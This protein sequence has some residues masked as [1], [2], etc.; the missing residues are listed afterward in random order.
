MPES[1]VSDT[2]T[3]VLRD[4]HQLILG[5]VD[6]LDRTLSDTHSAS[7]LDLDVID[8]C[9]SFFRLFA[10]A[11]HHGKEEDLLFPELVEHGMPGDAGPIAVM[12]SEH[13]QGRLFVRGMA[14]AMAGAGSGNE[15]SISA[16]RSHAEDYI[17]LIRAH[18]GKEDHILFVMADD[19]VVGD[20]CRVLCD[21]YDVVCSRR[22]E[23][24]TKGDLEAI[25]ASLMAG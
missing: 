3:G 9:I 7:E 10:D 25:A 4:E 21:R 12:L 5:V 11:C 13:V 17:N 14:E 22:F 19:M 1:P 16:L 15:D 8:R 6:V 23:G 18:I 24:K 20:A 2:A